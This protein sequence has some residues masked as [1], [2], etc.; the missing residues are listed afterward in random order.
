MGG[1]EQEQGGAKVEEGTRAAQTVDKPTGKVGKVSWEED[2]QQSNF[3]DKLIDR[4]ELYSPIGTSFLLLLILSL[5]Y[6]IMLI[7]INI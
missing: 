7:Y 3:L 4:S 1:K 6:F 2:A 5:F